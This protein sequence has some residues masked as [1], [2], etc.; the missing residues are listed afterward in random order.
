MA[1]NWETVKIFLTS[2]GKDFTS[3]RD[4]ILK[5]VM[6]K[7]RFWH[8]F[9]IEFVQKILSCVSVS[10][11]SWQVLVD[12]ETWCETKKI[13]VEVTDIRWVCLILFLC[14]KWMSFMKIID[15][16]IHIMYSD[17]Y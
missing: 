2:Y 16:R 4:A 7:Y 14:G 5:E 10:L 15:D 3:E 12:F 13:Q 6:F 11:Y 8:P 1:S 9:K 17:M